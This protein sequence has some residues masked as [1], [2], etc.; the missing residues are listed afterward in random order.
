[1]W[2]AIEKRIGDES[3]SKPLYKQHFFLLLGADLVIYKLL[4]M[5]PARDLGF[6]FKFAPLIFV[7]ALF[8]MFGEN[9]FRINTELKLEG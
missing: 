3:I 6:S 2:L 9:P 1:M 5:I 7:A 8:Y 4:E